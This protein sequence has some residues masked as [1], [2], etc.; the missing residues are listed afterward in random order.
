MSVCFLQNL[1]V[2]PL[3]SKNWNDTEI[4]DCSEKRGK[5]CATNYKATDEHNKRTRSQSRIEDKINW[6]S[7]FRQ[8]IWLDEKVTT[9]S[10]KQ[11]DWR[12]R[13]KRYRDNGRFKIEGWSVQVLWYSELDKNSRGEWGMV[14][15]VKK[16]KETT[17]LWRIKVW[18]GYEYWNIRIWTG[19]NWEK[20][21]ENN[22]L[23][24]RSVVGRKCLINMLMINVMTNILLVPVGFVCFWL[25]I[26]LDEKVTIWSLKQLVWKSHITPTD[27]WRLRDNLLT[28]SGKQCVWCGRG[29]TFVSV[30]LSVYTGHLSFCQNVNI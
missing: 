30:L 28:Y 4:A 23:C 2:R 17:M 29:R 16:H 18:P 5:M 15:K 22:R 8:D 10:V 19:E 7:V 3:K 21:V 6:A 13:D 9:W 11:V 20:S 24:I 14:S 1:W 12:I 26:C 25:D 27:V